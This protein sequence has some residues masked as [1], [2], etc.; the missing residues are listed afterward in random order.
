MEYRTH[1]A[2]LV[3][4][5]LSLVVINVFSHSVDFGYDSYEYVRMD[6]LVSE[7]LTSS[8]RIADIYT[9]CG[10]AMVTEFFPH[11]DIEPM[12][13]PDYNVDDDSLHLVRNS[14]QNNNKKKKM[15]NA[16][17]QN[18]LTATEKLQIAL[19]MAEGIADL[20]GFPDGVI[21]HNDIQPSQ[22]L[23]SSNN[24]NKDRRLKL[25]DFNRAEIMLWDEQ[26]H[27]YCR[28]HNGIGMGN[29]S[30]GGFLELSVTACIAQSYT[31]CAWCC[32]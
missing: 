19:A 11:G 9:H 4:L 29:V 30:G 23:F 16:Q 13:V 31:T 8:P 26:H 14:R 28:Y 25:N 1:Q 18:N 22:F 15:E 12:V 3:C 32:V 24:N 21:V 10:L 20:H 5:S 27:S 7:R 6:A 17:S 2:S